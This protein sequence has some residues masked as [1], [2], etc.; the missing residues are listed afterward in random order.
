[1]LFRLLPIAP[2]KPLLDKALGYFAPANPDAE[3]SLLS[4]QQKFFNQIKPTHQG[5]T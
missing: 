3:N 2:S 4:R 1:L 5:V